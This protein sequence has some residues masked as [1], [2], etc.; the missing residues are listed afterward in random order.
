MNESLCEVLDNANIQNPQETTQ[1]NPEK[2]LK[3]MKQCI[4][5][6]CWKRKLKDNLCKLLYI[7]VMSQIGEQESKHLKKSVC[8]KYLVILLGI[9]IKY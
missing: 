1:S 3:S 6:N 9:V 5:R 4:C 8:N 2:K 7:F